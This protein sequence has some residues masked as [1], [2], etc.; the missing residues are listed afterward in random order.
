[1]GIL[2]RSTSRL[3]EIGFR[4]VGVD[5][6]VEGVEHLPL[7]GPAIVASNHVGYLDFAFV[8][9]AP[10]RP[11][12]EV[13]FLAR[14]DLF[15]RPAVGRL[16]RALGQV[17]VDEHGDPEGTLRRAR[18]LLEAGELVGL[19][20]E[21]TV[22]PT[23]LPL[24]GKSGAIRLAQ[25]T[26]VPIV[27]ASVWGTQRLLTKWRPP[28]WPERGIPIQVRYGAPYMPPPV[29][30][31]TGAAAT[32]ELMGRITELVERSIATESAPPGSWWVP[33]ERGGGAPRLAD[34]E[35]GLQAQIEERRS[36]R[37]LRGHRR[38]TAGD[39]S[40]DPAASTGS[41]DGT[42]EDDRG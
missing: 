38:L 25:Q 42:R 23:F 9:L 32:R 6:H 3:F 18:E 5:V 20:P 28:A 4:A 34:V 22:N 39:G 36:A 33:A 27:P 16:L 17:P 30:E 2:Y 14:G 12:R 37:Q 31:V 26:G 29:G 7:Q 19:H 40:P 21:G 35:A 1:M 11:R 15:E 10:P 24:R 41:P 13:R 8:M